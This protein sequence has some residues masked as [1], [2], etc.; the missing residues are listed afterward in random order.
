M[1]DL[2][3]AG[4][5]PQPSAQDV[6]FLHLLLKTMARGGDVKALRSREAFNK[7]YAWA[8]AAEKALEES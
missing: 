8:H 1:S 4:K 2:R 6:R 5:A 7:L 3:I